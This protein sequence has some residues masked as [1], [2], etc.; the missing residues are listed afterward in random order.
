MAAL[1]LPVLFICLATLFSLSL[2]SQ[3]QE[4]TPITR[5]QQYLKINTAHPNPNYTTPISFL[6][7]QANSIGLQSQILEFAPSKPV[8]LLTWPGSNPSL[9]SIL[10]NSHLDSVPAEPSKWVNPPFSA[11]RTSDG[12]IF[13]RGAQDDKCIG[14][15]Y[16][17]AIRNLK[18]KNVNLLRTV[19]ISYVPD[20]EIGGF[21]GCA[22]FVKSKEFKD[23]N[24]G[25]VLDEG[26]ASTGDEF[27]VF[28][29]D[30]TPWGLIIKSTGAPGHGSKMYDNGAME[31]L[32]KS[33]E[34]IGRFRESQFDIVKAGEAANSEVISANPVYLKA[35]IP[36][37]DGFVM[38]MQPSEAEAGFDLRLPPTADPDLIRKRIAEEWAPARR[39]MTFQIIEKGPIRD[40]MGHPLMTLTNASN[41]W[42]T[43][44]NQAIE[45]A[46]G[47]L[48]KPEILAST[49]DARY[50]RQ[51]GIPALGFSPM[52]NTPI[53]LHDHNE[54]LKDTVYLRGIEVYEYVISSLASF[55]GES[56]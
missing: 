51:L 19:H 25:F 16:L 33:V 20:E 14:M 46:G 43:V 49:T 21:E 53:L 5:F 4:D 15:Q 38:N 56:H 40:L 52:T 6:L 2:Q 37:S 36:S 7:S 17:E 45:A 42:W 10:F 18:A 13:A 31:N 29:A 1:T 34:V 27:R 23:L 12:K 30:R 3:E 9:P 44:F 41:P 8:L 35:G 54:F 55:D 24:L 48:A 22:L 11:T 32:M 50:I 26:Q 28:Y 39:N 47:K